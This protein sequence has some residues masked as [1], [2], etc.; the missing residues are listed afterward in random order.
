MKKKILFVICLLFGLMFINAGL[1]KFLNYIPVPDDMPEEMVKL[2]EAFMSISWLMP[3]IATV[4][5]VGG[6]L[7][8]I[9]KF[10]ALGAI[11]I[12]PIV[13]GIVLTH[14]INEP[15]GLPVALVLLLIN[16]WVF[17]ENREKYLPMIK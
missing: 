17:F 5:I 11:I 9:P 14:T 15:S 10:R 3:L 16:L 1:N 12:F 4:E 2:M 13:V 8:I 7:F 6:I